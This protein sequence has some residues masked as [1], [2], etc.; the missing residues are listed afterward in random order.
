MPGSIDERHMERANPTF[1]HGGRMDSGWYD[2]GGHLPFFA[3]ISC[4]LPTEGGVDD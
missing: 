3:A 1:G 4:R 2:A